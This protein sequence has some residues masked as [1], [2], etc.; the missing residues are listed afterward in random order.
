MG[1]G[2]LASAPMLA[3][4]GLRQQAGLDDDSWLLTLRDSHHPLAWTL[5]QHNENRIIL[6]K[7]PTLIDSDIPGLMITSSLTLQ[8]F[9][10]VALGSGIIA[11]LWRKVLL[12]R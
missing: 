11:I 9:L 8:S 1:T 3:R 4:L 6:A 12:N 2:V 10:L 7:L 5:I